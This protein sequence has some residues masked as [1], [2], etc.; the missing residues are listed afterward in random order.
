MGG[1]LSNIVMLIKPTPLFKDFSSVHVSLRKKCGQVNNWC[2]QEW[3]FYINIFKSHLIDVDIDIFQTCWYI[4]Q[5]YPKA[6]SLPSWSPEIQLLF[7]CA[8]KFPLQSRGISFCWLNDVQLERSSLKVPKYLTSW[9][10]TVLSGCQAMNYQWNK[11]CKSTFSNFICPHPGPAI[12]SVILCVNL[13][14]PTI[15]H[16]FCANVL[17]FTP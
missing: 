7:W 16:C 13:C 5:G 1:V 11:L 4:D 14:R 2:F 9:R 12:R 17:I 10:R 3:P 6:L 15:I 8:C